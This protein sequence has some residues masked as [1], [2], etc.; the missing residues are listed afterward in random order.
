M[1]DLPSYYIY[2]QNIINMSCGNFFCATCHNLKPS[3][4]IIMND[5]NQYFEKKMMS[6]NLHNAMC[7]NL[8]NG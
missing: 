7:Y 1:Y 8:I 5:E 2:I 6:K 4:I 3:L